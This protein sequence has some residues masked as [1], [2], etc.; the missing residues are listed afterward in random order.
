MVNNW[1]LTT[2]LCCFPPPFPSSSL[3]TLLPMLSQAPHPLFCSI[4]HQL[5]SDIWILIFFSTLSPYFILFLSSSP[6][7]LAFPSLSTIL[8]LVSPNRSKDVSHFSEQWLNSSQLWGHSPG[9]PPKGG[10]NVQWAAYSNIWSIT[11]AM[12]VLLRKGTD[13]LKIINFLNS[14]EC[15]KHSSDLCW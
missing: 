7:F 2:R 12:K 9:K 1:S 15:V 3:F 10:E 14:S 4:H 6:N 8:S 13:M 5:V 11:V